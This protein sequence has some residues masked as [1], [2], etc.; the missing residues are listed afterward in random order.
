MAALLALDAGD[1]STEA[2]AMGLF[3]AMDRV[4]LARGLPKHLKVY[5]VAGAHQLVFGVAPPAVPE[6]VTAKL[7][8]GLWL[9]YL[10]DVARAAGHPVPVKATHP[11][12][13]EPWAFGGVVAGYADKLRADAAKLDRAAPLGK[14]VAAIVARLDAEWAEVPSIAAS[15]KAM[16]DRE[17]AERAKKK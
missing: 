13:R 14:A 6:D 5:A 2:H 9:R 16:A 11:R 4:E 8:R 15:Q 10:A 3:C 1:L 17:E 7:E 12:E